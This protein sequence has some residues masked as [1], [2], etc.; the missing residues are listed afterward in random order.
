MESI[1]NVFRKLGQYIKWGIQSF[2]KL[3]QLWFDKMANSGSNPKT[4]A[5]AVSG[6]MLVCLACF[7]PL[8]CLGSL[9]GAPEATSVAIE[10]M[11]EVAEPYSESAVD[12]NSDV[13]AVLSEATSI[14]SS[15]SPAT[16]TPAPTATTKPSA[17]PKPTNTTKPTKTS[18]PTNTPQP[19]I[20]PL[21]VGMA[22][23]TGVNN[24]PVLGE[25]AYVNYVVDGDT[26]NV[27]MNDEEYRVRY[28][29]MNT[30]EKG[31]PFAD[32]ATQANQELVQDQTVIMVKDVSETDRYGRLLR[33][34]Y[35]ADGTMVNADLVRQGFA[36]I[37]TYP[38]DV[39]HDALFFGVAAGGTEQW[40][41]FVGATSSNQYPC[42]LAYKY[43]GTISYSN[44]CPTACRYSGSTSTSDRA[45]ATSKQL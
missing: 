9:I 11:D 21:P 7:V 8:S 41:W 28:I 19:S 25:E 2:I 33:Y 4:L 15:T 36:Q 6:L 37:A 18:Q 1:V 42:S 16:G 34:V 30:P 24:E 40:S 17:T 22:L 44:A 35:L 45:A 38:P 12:E 43:T 31:Q 5:W 23:V 32:L 3:I 10:P 26:I 13:A 27:V 39:N 20:T 14:L 29:G